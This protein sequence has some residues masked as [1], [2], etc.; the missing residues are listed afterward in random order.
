MLADDTHGVCTA[1]RRA[2]HARRPVLCLRFCT[3][4]T[5]LLHRGKVRV[6]EAT[7]ALIGQVPRAVAQPRVE[8]LVRVRVGVGVRVGVRVQVR[9]RV[10]VR[11]GVRVRLRVRVRVRWY[12]SAFS[13]GRRDGCSK[14]WEQL[15][16]SLP[17]SAAW[18]RPW[19]IPCAP[20]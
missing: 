10:R 11:V 14:S 6:Q 1:C 5:E 13:S 17:S 4:C 9:V 8:R 7:L 15:K 18:K 16:A 19:P 3:E 2:L 20:G 12:G